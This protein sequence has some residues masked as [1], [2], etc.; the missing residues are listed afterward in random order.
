[1]SLTSYRTAPPRGKPVIGFRAIERDRVLT[2]DRLRLILGTLGRPGGDLLSHALRRST[3]GAEGFHDRVRNGIGWGTLAITTRSS[4]GTST[5]RPKRA[6]RQCLSWG[7]TFVS[8]HAPGLSIRMEVTV[9]S[10]EQLVQVSYTYYYASTPCLSTWSS[11]TALK[12]EL[13]SRGASR[14]D[15]FSGYPVRT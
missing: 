2:T 9:K 8:A 11:S 1:M 14:L 3:I 10:I 7:V 12:G 5:R 6:E 13:V 15:A 4:K